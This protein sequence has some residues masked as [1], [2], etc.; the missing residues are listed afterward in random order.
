MAS[1]MPEPHKMKFGGVPPMAMQ[2]LSVD[3]CPRVVGS[4]GPGH[5]GHVQPGREISPRP[6]EGMVH[7]SVILRGGFLLQ[8]S[9]MVLASPFFVALDP[10]PEGIGLALQVVGQEC[11]GRS[12]QCTAG[13]IQTT[14][15][16]GLC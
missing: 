6:V 4:A 8:A 5:R 1:G 7:V 2:T 3:G 9:L 15:G 12:I 13:K 14:G 10:I 16:S 11:N